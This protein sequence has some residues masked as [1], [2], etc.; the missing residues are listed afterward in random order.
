VLLYIIYFGYTFGCFFIPRILD[1][2]GRKIPFVIFMALQVPIYLIL[3]ISSSYSL[4][5]IMLFIFGMIFVIRYNGAWINIS[6]YTHGSYQNIL[7]IWLLV[8]D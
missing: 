2:Y 8:C 1:V 4:T 3:I 6:E 5:S 7:A